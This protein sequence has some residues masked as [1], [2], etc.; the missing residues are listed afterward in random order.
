MLSLH[1]RMRLAP[2]D[3]I[4][5]LTELGCYNYLTRVEMF[6]T[7]K[8]SECVTLELADLVSKLLSKGYSSSPSNA[9][10]LE[11]SASPI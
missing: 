2:D 1:P 3:C 11:F 6:S 7:S 8:C 4:L 10:T 5:C 9:S